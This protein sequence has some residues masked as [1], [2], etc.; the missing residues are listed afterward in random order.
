MA[1]IA[2][3]INDAGLTVLDA[4]QILYREPGFALLEDDSVT[5][6]NEAFR[7]ARINPRRIQHQFWSE[8][9]TDPIADKRFAHMSPADLVAVQLEQM[10]AQAGG[11]ELIVAVPAYLSA[12]QLGLMLGIAGELGVQVAALVDAAVAAT[13]REYRNAV[14]VHIDMSLHTTTLSRLAQPGR[15]QLDRSEVLPGLGTYALYDAWLNSVVE[16]AR[17]FDDQWS[18][19]VEESWTVILGHVVNHM[20]RHY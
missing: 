15:V 19:E 2:A 13:R 6:G 1:R 17:D 7:N 11:A 20:I 3:H 12:Q 8:L 14:P 16:T 18:D 10:L 4:S 5:T 9:T